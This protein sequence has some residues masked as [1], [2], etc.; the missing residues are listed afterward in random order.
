[1]TRHLR[2]CSTPWELIPK[3]EVPH[4]ASPVCSQWPK[5]LSEHRQ[6]DETLK[7]IDLSRA[8]PGASFLQPAVMSR[9][10]FRT[11]TAPGF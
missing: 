11:L 3:C 5:D 9:R 4:T 2:S 8:G 1:M 10:I 7:L 6:L